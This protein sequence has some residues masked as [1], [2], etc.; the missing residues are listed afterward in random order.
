MFSNPLFQKGS[1]LIPSQFPHG[2]G[3]EA[4]AKAWQCDVADILDLSTGLHPSGAPDWL[5]KW[6]EKHADLVAQY[7]DVNGDPARA[8]LAQYFNVA[9]ENILIIAGAQ[10]LIETIFQAMPWQSMAIE[11]PCYNEPIRCAQRTG[12]QVHGFEHDEPIPLTDMLWLT[13][14]HNP[15]GEEKVFPQGRQGVLDESYMPFAQR[16]NLGLIAGVIRLG[17]LTKTFCIPGLRLGYVVAD[18][19]T[20]QQLHH[21]LAPWPASTLGLHILPK[22]LD[23][24]DVRDAQIQSSRQQL[25]A[26]LEKHGWKVNPSS[27]SFVLAKP[28]GEAPD[29]AA[30]KILVR[31]FPE[32]Q[33]LSGWVRFGFPN[34]KQEWQR[35]EDVLTTSS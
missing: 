24:A 11:V 3:I 34:V 31:H 27:A 10:A 7:P 5:P 14:P 21:W 8:V 22:L 17:S 1:A 20:I 25:I 2:G 6:L 28:S 4:A 29:F 19:A 16:I 18:A 13:S 12:C 26:L 9:A 33:Q 35:L 23:E 30:A 15:T 32:W